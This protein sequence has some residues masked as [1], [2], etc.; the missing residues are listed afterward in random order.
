M[1]S[2]KDPLELQM[3]NEQLGNFLD[4]NGLPLTS[5][6]GRKQDEPAE[7]DAFQE[8][9]FLGA[10]AIDYY[11]FSVSTAG[12]VNG[13][14]YSDFIVG[15]PFND[16]GGA[17]AGRAYIYYGGQ[18]L[19]YN[20]DVV[21]TG[22]IA[23][24]KLGFSVSS[25]GDVNADGFADVVVGANGVSINNGGAYVYLGGSPMNNVADVTLQGQAAG[26]LFGTSVSHA[27][28]LNGDSFSD[29]IIGAYGYNGYMGRAYVYYGA[30]SMNSGIDLIFSS[31]HSGSGYGYAISS[32]G[33]FNS[34]GYGDL[35]IGE[36]LG[37]GSYGMAFIYTGGPNMDNT[38]DLT[39]TGALPA[40]YFAASLGPAGDVNGD[41][42]DDVIVGSYMYNSQTGRADIYYGG[43]VLNNVSDVQLSGVAVSDIFGTSVSGAFDVN[44]DG[45]KDVIVGSRQSD[46]GG[47]N[48]GCAYVYHGGIN[49]NNVPDAVLTAN[50]PNDQFGFCVASA[51]DVNRDGLSDLIVGVPYND[52][53]GSDAGKVWLYT[54]T[55]NRTPLPLAEFTGPGGFDYFGLRSSN[56][57]DLNGDGYDDV[58]SSSINYQAVYIFYG[59]RFLDN[60]PDLILY[61][62]NG[63]ESFTSSISEAGDVNGDGFDDIIIG[64][65]NSNGATGRAYIFYGG[66]NMNST[67][68]V[69][70]SGLA[71][72]NYFG[73]AV[74]GGGDVNFDGYDDVVV[75][76]R[77][78]QVAY[79]FYGGA[80]MNN[81]PDVTLTGNLNGF[82]SS[83]AIA[84]SVNGDVYDDVLVGAN[85]DGPND[86]GMVYLFL[87]S[88]SMNNTFD[89]TFTGPG[90][91]ARYGSLVSPA[92]D[93]NS[94]GYDDFLVGGLN[95]S[96]LILDTKGRVDLFLGSPSVDN[97]PDAVM[98]GLDANYQLGGSM[99][100]IGDYNKDGYDDYA[101]TSFPAK[102][103][104]MFFGG[105][106]TD[107][108]PEL[109]LAG[110]D[111]NTNIYFGMSVSTAGD[112][113]GDG[114]PEIIAG[115]YG[116]S[117]QGY[118]YVF[119]YTQTITD[120]HDAVF[121]GEA[122]GDWMGYAIASAGDVNSDGYSDVI[123]GARL[124]DA[125]GLDAGRA[126]IYFGGN[127]MDFV[128]DVILNGLT[129][130]DQFGFSVAGTGDV[131]GDGYG[132]V[133]VGAPLNDAAG[134][135]AGR[136]Y[137]YYGGASMN[138]LVDVVLTGEFSGNQFGFRV[139]GA[140]NFNGDNF[141]DIWQ[142]VI[143][144][145]PYND[146]GGTHAGRAYVYFGG[147]TMNNVV[148]VVITGAAAFNNLGVSVAAAGDVNG[149]T[150]GDI[151]VGASGSDVAATDAGQAFIYYGSMF[152]DNAADVTMNGSAA[153]DWFGYSVASAGDVNADGYKDVVVGAF[154]N[155]QRAV[156]AGRA[157]VFYG[158]L[159]MNNAADMNYYGENTN[160]WFGIC[161]ASAGDVNSDGLSDIIVGSVFNDAGG[162]D[163]GRAYIYF[164]SANINNNPDITLTGKTGEFFGW[165]V[166]GGGDINADGQSDPLV[167]AYQSSIT[168]PQN[169]RGYLFISSHPVNHL[170]LTLKSI[171]QGYYDASS[172]T[173][174]KQDTLTVNLRNQSF[175]YSV[176]GTAKAVVSKLDF[177][178]RFYFGN[179]APGYY[180]IEVKHRNS[181]RTWSS[182]PQAFKRNI[183]TEYDMTAHPG[184]AYGSNMILVDNSPV[185]YAI[186]GG[187]VNQDGIV[188][189]VDALLVDNDSFNFLTGYYSTDVNGDYSVDLADALLVDNNSTNF[190]GTVIP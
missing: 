177:T 45:F 10:A 176:A 1:S 179:V 146:A 142:D 97:I 188:D 87:G 47:T 60:I 145:S 184:R 74:S 30:A 78:N 189:A 119:S 86:E 135:D 124:N 79:V 90:I 58:M 40:D 120:I 100:D 165:F 114:Y 138:N 134:T 112:M 185:R 11:G 99:S 46:N 65:E 123:V 81:V 27:G 66:T 70:L 9:Q 133:I 25:A 64:A 71:G 3:P 69:I 36:F 13:D 158:G 83:V 56:A 93:V 103:V 125:P 183:A 34:D 76:S 182:Q 140:G 73:S 168:S 190:V 57:G 166:A 150:Y 163:A 5:N 43:N 61:A 121:D 161:V 108:I 126:Y 55:R 31:G 181:I 92:G 128:P 4:E 96:F 54:N 62:P 80:V 118:V 75:G 33:D 21:L 16:A 160:D 35:L 49:M 51:G 38:A 143:I 23:G 137:I 8:Y 106:S 89:Q 50:I 2:D 102:R 42:F 152:P 95:P 187:D 147:Y 178:A 113:N 7:G 172:E 67:P 117:T 26:E 17:D 111:V 91:N 151:I 110:E 132:D 84:G 68:D 19:D 48:A 167:G 144:G 154:R 20:A 174:N 101:V 14:G 159:P 153:G 148:D 162:T 149:D 104:Y 39:L 173:L 88:A 127:P 141:G 37:P 44:G 105:T 6:A 164:G 59:G 53:V 122:A 29:V 139:A 129:A 130:G 63:N 22:N 18:I 170:L 131:N 171:L 15:A 115:G 24:G 12:D 77:G 136:A 94:D 116:L 169:G 109:V 41:G 180:W 156:D 32:A 107:N 155:D 82:G 28:D 52:Q 98:I 85:L 157:Y 175:P 186:Y 72:N